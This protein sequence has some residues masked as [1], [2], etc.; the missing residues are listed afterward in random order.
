[1]SLEWNGP[2]AALQQADGGYGPPV[3]CQTDQRPAT[4]PALVDMTT[5][6][7]SLLSRKQ[8]SNGF[9]LQVEGASIDK[10]DHAA[11]ACA[12]IGETI[13]FDNAIKVAQEYARSHPD[14]LIV[15]TADHA[16]TSQIVAEDSS[17]TGNPTG[18][19]NNLTT[20]D[21]QT[22]RVTYGTAGGATPPAAP[23]SQQHTGSVVPAFASGPGAAAVLGTTDHTD[24]FEVLSGG[25]GR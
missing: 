2:T 14:T 16:H 4:E 10:Q 7:I 17:G 8:H 3:T 12:Q 6:A 23:P 1:M 20:A 15:V 5:K 25:H 9:F 22:L 11:N 24:L 21:D 18:Y 19:S 13:A